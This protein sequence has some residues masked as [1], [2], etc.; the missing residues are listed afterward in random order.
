MNEDQMKGKANQVKGEVKDRAGGAMGDSSTQAEGK[1][2]K[3]GGKIQEGVGN[4]KE[5][6]KGEDKPDHD[7]DRK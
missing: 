4:M 2:D 3:L 7:L 5:K 6:L 1:M